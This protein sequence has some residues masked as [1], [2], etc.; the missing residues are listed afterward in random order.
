[1]LIEKNIKPAINDIV[2]VKL[3]S[4]EEIVGRLTSNT[5]EGIVLAKPIMIVIQ[6]ASGG[7]IGIRFFPVLGSIDKDA[8]LSIAK[9]GMSIGLVKTRKDVADSYT[10]ATSGIATVTSDQM[11][12]I[13][14]S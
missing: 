6:P 7:Q 1:M 12:S 5:A 11:S 3:T 4:G 2:T 10:Q 13:I 8:S 14:R 9:S